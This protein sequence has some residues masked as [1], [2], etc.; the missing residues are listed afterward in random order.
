MTELREEYGLKGIAL[1]GY[2]RDADVARSARAGFV[3]HLTKP[4]RVQAL[5]AA[6]A[7]AS[8]LDGTE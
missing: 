1:T 3:A 6:L 8:N 4:V 7:A 5:D 2:G